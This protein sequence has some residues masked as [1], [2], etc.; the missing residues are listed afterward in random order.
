M[1]MKILVVLDSFYPNVDG[2]I[3]VVVSVARKFKEK[4]LGDMELLVPAYPEKAEAEGVTVHRCRSFPAGE[5]RGAVP[6][7]DAKVKK[8]I[9]KGGYDI[10]HLHSPFT[11]GRYA[12][13][14]GRKH[15]IPVIFTMHTKFRDEFERRLK[16]RV[17]QN[18]MMN[19]IM[20]CINGCDVVTTVSQGTVD[21]LGEYGYKNTDKVKVIR[22]AASMT[23]DVADPQTTRK[24]REEINPDGC[25]TFAYVGRLAQTKNIPFSLQALAEAKKRGC[26][27]FKFVLVGSGDYGKTLKRLAEEYGLKDNVVFT[28]KITDKKLLANYYAACDALL[29]PSMFDNASIVI[30]EAAANSLPVATLKNSCSA[31][32]IKDGESGFVWEND[33]NVWAENIVRLVENPQLAKSA[34]EGALRD[35]YVGWDNIAEEYY[36]L[37]REISGE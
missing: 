9:A 34:G 6:A 22:N 13:K 5:Y 23:P 36:K 31:E 2:P 1:F 20:K 14:Y 30:L 24:I 8:L 37:Y 25:F 15:G 4:G 10:I 18:F 12:M 11:L 32:K 29:F 27:P 17:L 3:E 33:V 16:S 28:G 26:K 7:F 19:Y 21:T 35:V